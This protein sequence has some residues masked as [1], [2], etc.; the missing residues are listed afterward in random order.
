MPSSAE[1]SYV[2]PETKVEVKEEDPLK[3]ED[4]EKLY[5]LGQAATEAAAE[6]KNLVNPTKE[7][8]SIRGLLT[9]KDILVDL[10]EHMT[11]ENRQFAPISAA[12]LEIG[13][14]QADEGRKMNK[15]T[16][17]LEGRED[18]LA[19]IKNKC[20]E[21]AD[22]FDQFIKSPDSFRSFKPSVTSQLGQFCEILSQE[23]KL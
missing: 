14:A 22:L 4:P 6:F 12:F 20:V 2:E 5:E 7:Q 1:L 17:E 18:E 21:F 16:N 23:P 13:F 15:E 10:G 8:A 9:F 11:Q 19:Y 3:L